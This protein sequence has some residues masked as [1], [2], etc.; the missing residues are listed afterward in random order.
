LNGLSAQISFPIFATGRARVA[1]ADA[2]IAQADYQAEATRRLIPLEVER[3]LATLIA[4]TKAVEHADHHVRQQLQLE[5]LASRNYQQGNGDYM[6][7]VEAKRRR[8]ASQMEQLQAQQMLRTAYVELE[9][10]TGVAMQNS[11]STP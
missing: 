1:L 10:A 7:V 4:N 5:T 3:A 2:K 9:R 11:F 6:N 8:L